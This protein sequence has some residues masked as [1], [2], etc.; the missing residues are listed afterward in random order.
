MHRKN[1]IAFKEW[2][3]VCAALGSGR[4]AIIVRKGGIDEGR[5]GFRIRHGEFWLLPTRFHQD[6]AGLVPDAEP[7][8]RAVQQ[9]APAAGMFRIELYAVVEQVF[10]V[11]D[12]AALEG[13][14]SEHILSQAT[15]EQRFYYRQP[16]L[17]VLAVRVYRVPQPFEIEDTPYIAGC[18]SWVELPAA[19]DTNGLIPVLDEAAFAQRMNAVRK[20]L[21]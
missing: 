13:L 12:L 10:E 18:K 3:V 9:S 17:F 19:I 5:E 7:L 16:G 11:R 2:A 14:A 8:L 20:K 1:N 6:A 15:I 21:V 4:Q